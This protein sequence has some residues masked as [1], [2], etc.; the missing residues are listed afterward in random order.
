MVVRVVGDRVQ[1]VIAHH[2]KRVSRVD[3]GSGNIDHLALMAAAVDEIPQ[4]DHF[5]H[6]VL[7][8][9]GAVFV[10]ESVQQQLQTLTMAVYIANDVETHVCPAR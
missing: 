10:A 8:A 3:H 6:G 2:R 5:A 7:V 9:A 4:K 1:L